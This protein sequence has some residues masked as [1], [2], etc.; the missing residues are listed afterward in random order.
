M[1]PEF[2]KCYGKNHFFS[3]KIPAKVVLRSFIVSSPSSISPSCKNIL[4][5]D[6]TILMWDWENAWNEDSVQS[7]KRD[8]RSLKMSTHLSIFSEKWVFLCSSIFLHSWWSIRALWHCAGLRIWK[9]VSFCKDYQ[10]WV[11]L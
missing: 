9:N 11:H 10:E 4:S 1:F 2:R 5:G 3:P 6:E 7:E 8:W